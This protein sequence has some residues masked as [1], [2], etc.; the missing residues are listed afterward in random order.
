MNIDILGSLD[1]LNR[2]LSQRGEKRRFVICGGASLV[3]QGVKGRGTADIDI[4]GP[5]I[6]RI[7]REA[8]LLVAK[9]LGLQANWLNDDA[10]KI[11]S[12]DLPSGW[13]DRVFKIYSASHLIVESLSK[14]DLAVLKLLAE[15]DRQ[16]DFQDLVDLDLSESEI[17]QVVAHAL[18]R[19]PGEVNW[20]LI[21]AEV[22]HKLRR[23]MNY[24]KA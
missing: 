5:S 10:Q 13:E 1:L 4:V 14:L 21:V 20:A 3:L 24:E 7:L 17:D 9:D 18:T 16:K 23:K 11:F 2:Y 6:D 22:K 12:R 15:C 8:A 19:D